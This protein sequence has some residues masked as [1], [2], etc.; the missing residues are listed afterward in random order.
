M[1]FPS[2]P[3]QGTS[4]Q[5]RCFG[6]AY[7]FFHADVWVP[8]GGAP[9]PCNSVKPKEA[10]IGPGVWAVCV[11]GFS[12]S[13]F[14]VCLLL[15]VVVAMWLGFHGWLSSFGSVSLCFPFPLEC[16]FHCMGVAGH[17]RLCGWVV[18][19]PLC[20]CCP[21]SLLFLKDLKQCF[22]L[23]SPFVDIDRVSRVLREPMCALYGACTVLILAASWR[24]GV[25][26]ILVR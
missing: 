7:F 16:T 5:V 1:I 21:R 17:C 11:C 9:C 23:T 22:I 26:A 20:G 6:F 24:A 13:S 3:F 4:G 14:V 18:S 2:G 19:L 10:G 12:F 8:R 25:A 15:V